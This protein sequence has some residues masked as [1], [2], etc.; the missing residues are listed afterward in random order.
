M[1]GKQ[2]GNSSNKGGRIGSNEGSR[3]KRGEHGGVF[4]LPPFL[5]VSVPGSCSGEQG[6]G[7]HGG[8]FHPTIG[9][10]L[11]GLPTLS[12]A[13]LSQNLLEALWKH[14][15]GT[16]GMALG[17]AQPHMSANHQQPQ[18]LQK[19]TQ[20]PPSS[21]VG[22]PQQL[23]Q[24]LVAQQQQHAVAM[25]PQPTAQHCIPVQ[26]TSEPILASPSPSVQM[27][28]HPPNTGPIHANGEQVLC[29]SAHGLGG[30]GVG[31]SDQSQQGAA[32]TWG[33]RPQQPQPTCCD[34]LLQERESSAQEANFVSAPFVFPVPRCAANVHGGGSEGQST[35]ATPMSGGC[36][37]PSSVISSHLFCNAEDRERDSFGVCPSTG[38]RFPLSTERGKEGSCIDD[39]VG[40]GTSVS[41]ETAQ[42]DGGGQEKKGRERDSP[43][44]FRSPVTPTTGHSLSSSVPPPGC[45]FRSVSTSGTTTAGGGGSHMDRLEAMQMTTLRGPS[46]T[47]QTNPTM[48]N[49]SP[50]AE[51]L[52]LSPCCP[53]TSHNQFVPTPSGHLSGSSILS[54][55]IALVQQ[56][57]LPTL[58]HVQQSQA[59]QSTAALFGEH[60]AGGPQIFLP[61]L[62]SQPSPAE[63]TAALPCHR[64]I[65]P[66]PFQ[67]CSISNGVATGTGQAPPLSN[68]Q[69]SEAAAPIPSR[70][71]IFPPPPSNPT[72]VAPGGLSLTPVPGGNERGKAECPAAAALIPSSVLPPTTTDPH[73]CTESVPPALFPAPVVLP[74]ATALFPVVTDPGRASPSPTPLREESEVLR[75]EE[76]GGGDRAKNAGSSITSKDPQSQSAHVI[77]SLSPR[78]RL[79]DGRENEAEMKREKERGG[80]HAVPPNYHSESTCGRREG[81]GKRQEGLSSSPAPLLRQIMSMAASA[82]AQARGQQLNKTGSPPSSSSSV[83]SLGA[84]SDEVPSPSNSSS[85]VSAPVSDSVSS[86]PISSDEKD[87]SRCSKASI[88]AGGR[89]ERRAGGLGGATSRHPLVQALLQ[90]Q[91]Q[92]ALKLL[93]G[94]ESLDPQSVQTIADPVREGVSE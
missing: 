45:C 90:H 85:A 75:G 93:E 63:A 8:S 28:A 57:Q 20:L 81:R 44:A 67:N 9:V 32:W 52:S 47:A 48:H 39:D 74:R 33:A 92:D 68:G 55:A 94:G 19:P 58:Q 36:C 31:V 38:L 50:P 27:T 11:G 24:L 41:L 25:Q 84:S 72:T 77:S 87:E 79:Q 66:H 1:T 2:F 86:R 21:L 65:P 42:G 70:P 37:L 29:G 17:G 12:A 43:P 83:S 61:S 16:R 18:M 49:H 34:A 62:L 51:A 3:E 46:L 26:Q 7:G 60:A 56:Q 69:L 73:S 22:L 89:K 80:E 10:G 59:E 4:P 71:F 91:P 78:V 5:P 54:A 13:S 76:R 6:A 35:Q 40:T 53:P 23:Q 64:T 88:I 30:M 15:T 82:Q 14:S